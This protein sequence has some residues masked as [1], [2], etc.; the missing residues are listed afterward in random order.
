MIRQID[1]YGRHVIFKVTT[2]KGKVVTYLAGPV[3]GAGDTGLLQPF[4]TLQAA[5]E[6]I[7]KPVTVQP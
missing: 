3:D 1:K 5:R 6:F 4:N 7:G 2:P